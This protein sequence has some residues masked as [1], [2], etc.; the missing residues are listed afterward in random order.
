M[1]SLFRG[2]AFPDPGFKFPCYD[3]REFRQEVA[4]IGRFW[5]N[6]D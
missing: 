2:D 3:S 4:E 6:N 5:A 1:H